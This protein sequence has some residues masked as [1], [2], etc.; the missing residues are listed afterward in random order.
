MEAKTKLCRETSVEG[1][2]QTSHEKKRT[3]DL[4]WRILHGAIAVNAF[5]S[6]I[7]PT[8]SKRCPFCEEE[9]TVFHCFYY[10]ERLCRLFNTLQDVFKGFGETWSRAAFILGVGFKKANASKWKL[11]NYLVGD[12]KLAIYTSRKNKVEESRAGNPQYFHCTN[13]S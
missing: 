6:V 11:M 1:F 4:Q 2:I 10:C 9:E 3:G 8:V 7:N 5:I 12:A 13:Q